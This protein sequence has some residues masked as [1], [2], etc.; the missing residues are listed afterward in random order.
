MIDLVIP[1]KDDYN[2]LEK[3]LDYL[4]GLTGI[5][6]IHV[7]DTPGEFS[8]KVQEVCQKFNIP[9]YSFYWN[10][11]YPKKRNWSLLNLNFTT[12]LIVFLDNDEQISQENIN[13][14]IDVF[15]N[16]EV[17]VIYFEFHNIFR[18]KLLKYGI[19]FKKSNCLRLGKAKYEKI[20]ENNWSKFDMEIHEQIK[21][22]DKSVF[23]RSKMLHYEFKDLHHYISKHNEYSNWEAKNWINGVNRNNLTK[24]QKLKY[25]LLKTPFLGVIYFITDYLIYLG[26][27]NGK[28]GLRF[29]LLKAFYFQLIYWK[30]Q[31]ES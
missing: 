3:Q 17:S 1:L 28:L 13:E 22:N 27:L 10:G 21:T 4:S 31:D 20:E 9:C 8:S 5:A 6:Q 2:T 7:V 19:K 30:I 16:P 23:A 18:G 24:R 25:F 15:Q 14:I 12:E 26:I 29:S 11:Q